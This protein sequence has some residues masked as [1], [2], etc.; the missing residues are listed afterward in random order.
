MEKKKE[1]I[2]VSACLAGV[3]CNYKGQDAFHPKIV[4][5][6]QSAEIVC[7]CPEILGGEPIPR[8]ACNL[9]GGDGHDVIKGKAKVIGIDGKDHTETFIRGAQKTLAIALKHNVTKAYLKKRSPS[10][11]KGK[12]YDAKGE[13][14]VN[15]NG[16]LAALLMEHGIEV[17]PL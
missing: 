14:L 2:L 11:G 17:I 15:G 4:G 1:T 9:V 8:P 3:K 16:I 6:L 10:C 12:I 7:V 13:H 5:E